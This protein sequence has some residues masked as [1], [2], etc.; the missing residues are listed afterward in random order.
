MHVVRTL[1]VPGLAV[2]AASGSFAASARL[3]AVVIDGVNNHDW[4]AGTAAI[5]TILARSEKPPDA[6][7]AATAA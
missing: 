6:V 7:F 3:S 2:L 5:R 1:A 4:A